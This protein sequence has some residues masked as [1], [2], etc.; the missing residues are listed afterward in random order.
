LQRGGDLA[1]GG[2]AVVI[3]VE[4]VAAVGSGPGFHEPASA[5]AALPPRRMLPGRGG[6]LSGA[7]E[8]ERPLLVVVACTCKV[9][10]TTQTL[11]QLSLISSTAT[12]LIWA[13]MA[14]EV[15]IMCVGTS[16]CA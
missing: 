10:H 11:L 16:A 2:E 5:G 1:A 7:G 8:G 9:E 6:G 4:A 15:E 3:V 14:V 12:R 13:H